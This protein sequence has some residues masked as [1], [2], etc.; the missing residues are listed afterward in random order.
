MVFSLLKLLLNTIMKLS[1]PRFLFFYPLLFLFSCGIVPSLETSILETVQV[2]NVVRRNLT[3][4]VRYS[5]SFDVSGLVGTGLIVSN[6]GE[7]LKIDANGNYK[8]SGTF[9]SGSNY[10]VKVKNQPSLPTQ[11]CTV[12]GGTGQIVQGDI[13]GTIKVTCSEVVPELVTVSVQGTVTGL[14]GS[15]L[16]ISNTT[17]SGTETLSIN[18]TSFA[19]LN[20]APSTSYALAVVSQPTNPSQTCVIDSPSL[21]GT[22]SSSGTKITVS[23]TTN[24]VSLQV[25]VVG[26]SGTIVTPVQ[27]TDGTTT[28]SFTASGTTQVLRTAPSGSSYTVSLVSNIFEQGTCSIPTPSGVLGAS[29][30]T[31]TVNCS[32]GFLVQGNLTNPG[33]SSN[34]ILGTGGILRLQYK[35]GACSG[36]SCSDQDISLTSSLTNFTFPSAL[37]PSGQFEVIIAS[38]PSAPSQICTVTGTG[39]TGTVTATSNVTNLIVDCSLPMPSFSVAGGTYDSDVT[40]SL[41]GEPGDSIYY[42]VGNGSQAAPA[43]P[44]TGTLFGSA[45]VVSSNTT[46]SFKAISCRSGWTGSNVSSATYTLQPLSPTPSIANNTG[47]NSGATIAFSSATVSSWTC[48]SFSSAPGTPADPVCGATANTC[49]S[50]STGNMI[51]PG[52]SDQN[53]KV[54]ACKVGYLSTNI[55]SLSYPVNTYIISGTLSSLTTPFGAGT[56]VL[57]ANGADDLTLSSNGSFGFSI[58]IPSGENYSVAIASQPQNPWQTCTLGNATGTITNANVTNVTLSCALNTFTITGNFTT[59]SALTG[60]LVINNGT[61]N[62]TINSGSNSGA[63]GFPTALASGTVYNMSITT[64]PPGQVCSI[65]SEISGTIAN[66]NI[67]NFAVNCVNGYRTDHSIASLPI[68]PLNLPTYQIKASTL[69]GSSATGSANLTGS[70]AQFNSPTGVTFDG[71]NYYV[72]DYGNHTIRRITPGGAATTFAGQTGVAGRQDGIGT[73]AS[74]NTPKGISTDGTFLYVTEYVGKRLRR[75]RISNQTVTTLAGDTTADDPG[76]SDLNGTGTS[77]RFGF[78]NDIVIDGNNLYLSDFSFNKVKIFNLGT[79]VVTTLAAGSPLSSPEGMTKIGNTLY[80]ANALGHTISTIDVTNGSQAGSS[81]GLNGVSGY[82]DGFTPIVRFNQPR[83]LINDGKN[84]YITDRGNSRIRKLNLANGR[85]STLSGNGGTTFS[86]GVGVM[87]GYNS[88]WYLL[89]EGKVLAIVHNNAVRRIVDNSLSAYY[90][91]NSTTLTLDYGGELANG[92]T[93]TIVGSASYGNGR[94]NETNGSLDFSAASYFNTNNPVSFTSTDSFSISLWVNPNSLGNYGLVG[95]TAFEFKLSMDSDGSLTFIN[96]GNATQTKYLAKS[97]KGALKAGVWSHVTYVFNRNLYEATANLGGRIFVNGRNVTVSSEDQNPGSTLK[98]TTDPVMIAGNIYLQPTSFLGRIADVR[99]YKKAL[100]EGE[101]NS[102]A[103][104]ATQAQVGSDYNTDA[105][106]LLVHYMLEGSSS[107]FLTDSGYLNQALSSTSLPSLTR[108]QDTRINSAASFLGSS[109]QFLSPSSISGYPS[110]AQNRTYCGWFYPTV[111]TGVQT[112]FS[113]GTDATNQAVLLETSGNN[114]LVF[115]LQGAVSLTASGLVRYNTWQHFC[116]T[117]DS[118]SGAVLYINGNNVASTGSFP[119]NTGSIAFNLGRNLSNTNFFT[120]RMD[121]FRIYNEALSQ[122]QVRRLT[123]RI[124][125]GLVARF[126]FANSLTDATG[127][128]FTLTSSG[129]SYQFDRFGGS[130]SV[131]RQTGSSSF[132]SAS[133]ISTDINDFTISLWVRPRSV[134]GSNANILENGN[135]CCNGY[136]VVMQGGTGKL[137]GLMGGVTWINTEAVLPVKVWSHVV[138]QRFGGNYR[139]FLNGASVPVDVITNLPP[140]PPTG[141]VGGTNFNGDIDDVSFYSIGLNTEEIQALSGPH[142]LQVNGWIPGNPSGTALKYHLQ[143]SSFETGDSVSTWLDTSSSGRSLSLVSTSPTINYPTNGTNVS[144]TYGASTSYQDPSSAL[145]FDGFSTVFYAENTQTDATNRFLLSYEATALPQLQIST[146]SSSSPYAYGLCQNA[147]G[148]GTLSS[149]VNTNVPFILNATRNSGNQTQMS[150]NG[151]SP[152]VGSLATIFNPVPI[153]GILTLGAN[154]IGGSNW[155]GS[156]SEFM[157]FSTTLTS[158]G[159]SH[160]PSITSPTLIDCYLSTKY[161]RPLSTSAVCP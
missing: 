63:G 57:Q 109:S 9:S 132:S 90:P 66:A 158:T 21:T 82:E 54:V 46:N 6:D 125:R 119:L 7:D 94:F 89:N 79:N 121:D 8:F 100:S 2:F 40:V 139:I 141:T 62:I 98:N 120:G 107:T 155:Q 99:I 104:D 3:P 10:D 64:S 88:L 5:V 47:L 58:G 60:N 86:A 159:N 161:Q 148:C 106:S 14:S 91:L 69:A 160:S 53:A 142:P 41:S 128:D 22:V 15:G 43:C 134:P 34:S 127:R 105:T 29:T 137:Y 35:G 75:I 138:L 135:G 44:S 13:S 72:A 140:N 144:L 153:S 80:V 93:G 45:V 102:Q 59:D 42:T 156:I 115:R 38:Q 23:C 16:Q 70:A 85:V 76:L 108:G 61:E 124:T 24:N 50:G 96:W 51:H 122:T 33:G 74:F 145:Q 123:A 116:A 97:F 154:F 20:Q 103:Q 65:A 136:N 19:F 49:N 56:L 83:G 133:A 11:T 81:W 130:S 143:A 126:D 78:L 48:R 17:S 39:T 114:D 52:V 110:A 73:A 131:L 101:L 149:T 18:G 150:I 68:I 36:G 27:V 1:F 146:M 31:V 84:L 32:Q 67:T 152:L 25:A 147:V 157:L 4:A 30:V 87:T 129:T 112:I 71:K 117:I 92:V 151:E 28:I 77:A 111:G 55:V 113:H 95:K 26:I 37:S 12:F 118:A